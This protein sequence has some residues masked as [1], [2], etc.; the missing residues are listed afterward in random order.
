MRLP[1]RCYDRDSLLL[2][3]GLKAELEDWR[4]ENSEERT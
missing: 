3:S 1:P 2:I 4:L